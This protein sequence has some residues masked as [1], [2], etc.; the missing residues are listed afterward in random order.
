MIDLTKITTPFG[1]LDAETQQALRDYKGQMEYYPTYGDWLH[2][3]VVNWHNN[4]TYRAKPAPV[5][6]PHI[7]WDFI[8]KKWLWAARDASGDLYVFPA[9]PR[10][11]SDT[12]SCTES[13]EVWDEVWDEVRDEI[14]AGTCDWKDS[15]VGRY[16]DET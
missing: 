5:T 2:V 4:S 14:D 12:W 9:K 8:D 6:K 7:P 11:T 15:L 13:A 1:L 3:Q 16:D 10:L